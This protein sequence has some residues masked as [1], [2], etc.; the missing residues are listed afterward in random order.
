VTTL[1]DTSVWIDFW[2]GRPSAARLAD[3]LDVD[4]VLVHPWVRAE[5]ALGPLGPKRPRILAD[6]AVLPAA[7]VVADE[8]VLAMV[9][10]RRLHGRGLGW[11]DVHLLASSLASG[12][13]LWT[14]DGSLASAARAAG[15]E[16][17]GR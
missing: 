4:E 8:E 7:A 14:H 6:L 12:G 2:R 3:L 13:T 9:D 11:V 15:V 16:W 10:A 1:V 5:I 17:A